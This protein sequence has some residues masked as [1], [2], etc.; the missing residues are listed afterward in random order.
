MTVLV[1]FSKA[2][3]NLMSNRECVCGFPKI[4]PV[5][6]VD[7]IDLVLGVVN[8]IDDSLL[9]D[10]EAGVILIVDTR[11]SLRSLARYGSGCAVYTVASVNL[12]SLL[13]CSNIELDTRVDTPDGERGS[14]AVVIVIFPAIVE[15]NTTCTAIFM[16]GSR[17][18]SSPNRLWDAEVESGVFDD[19]KVS[20]IRNERA[21]G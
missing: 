14:L 21:I 20:A 15:A 5:R 16:R 6:A 3:L 18:D 4:W 7:L 1:T 13:I 8:C 19:I 9:L 11:S 12:K 2:R 17:V 10:D